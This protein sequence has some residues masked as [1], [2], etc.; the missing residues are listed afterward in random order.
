MAW[1]ALTGTPT[2]LAGYG[3]T[4]AATSAQGTNADTAFGWGDHS[5]EGYLTEIPGA[6]ATDVTGSLFAD[7]SSTM[8]DAVNNAMFSDTL[9]LNV[10][11]AEPS[12][13]AN[14]MM[15]VADGTIWDPTTSGVQ[16][17][18]VYLGGAWRQIQTA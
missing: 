3:I 17:L 1:S 7:D 4:D 11:T 2:T 16:T 15:A 8:V 5:T 6:I 10:L 18:V 13:P 14:G 12:N 9:T